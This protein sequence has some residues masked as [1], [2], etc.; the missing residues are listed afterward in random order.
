MRTL[1]LGE[2]TY[3]VYVDRYVEIDAVTRALRERSFRVLPSGW[4][5]VRLGDDE[6]LLRPEGG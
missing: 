1:T 3:L 2:T 6:V 5:I 4:Y